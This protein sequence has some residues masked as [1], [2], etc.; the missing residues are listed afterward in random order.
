MMRIDNRSSARQSVAA[1][2]RRGRSAAALA[3]VAV[4]IVAATSAFSEYHRRHDD[5]DPHASLGDWKASSTMWQHGK[6]VACHREPGAGEIGDVH[7]AGSKPESHRE[8][9]WQVAHGHSHV[10]DENRC[11]VCHTVDQCRSCHERRPASHTAGF[12]H[13]SGDRPGAARHALLARLS[14]TNCLLCHN[15]PAKDCG[16]CHAPSETHQWQDEVIPELA[17]WS[18]L[19]RTGRRQGSGKLDSQAPPTNA[20]SAER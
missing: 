9:G 18:A 17:R 7:L 10:A 14:R 4:G 15:Q 13:P 8:A 20:K 6:C 3:V 2:R 5:S 12:V 16:T 11:Y 1:A 19:T